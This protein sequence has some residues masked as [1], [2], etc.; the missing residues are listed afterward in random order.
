MLTGLKIYQIT[1]SKSAINSKKLVKVERIVIKN[2]EGKITQDKIK[3]FMKN[4]GTE[5]KNKN[6]KSTTD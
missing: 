2:I 6:R 4:Q 5:N 3:N 1:Y